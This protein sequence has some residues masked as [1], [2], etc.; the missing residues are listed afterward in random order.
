M[1]AEDIKVTHEVLADKLFP[2]VSTSICFQIFS[3]EFAI[4]RWCIMAEFT[5]SKDGEESSIYT[6]DN[7]WEEEH[8]TL[9]ERK[10]KFINDGFSYEEVVEFANKT[11]ELICQCY[12]LPVVYQ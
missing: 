10:D 2:P 11:K 1:K 7:R 6:I 3:E 8:F 9:E 4:K 12:V 5:F